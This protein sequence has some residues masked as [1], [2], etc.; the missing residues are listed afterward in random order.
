MIASLI[1]KIEEAVSTSRIVV[2]SSIQKFFGPSKKEAYVT[3][4]LTFVDLSFLQFSL[5]VTE[6]NR[7]LVFGKYRYQYMDTSRKLVFRYDNAP[8]HKEI[9]TFPH[10]KHLKNVVVASSTPTFEELLEEI[11]TVIL[12]SS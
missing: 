6:K 1:E 9:S 12:R 7:R 2:T 8:H 4:R 3:G 5:F 10:H 11:S